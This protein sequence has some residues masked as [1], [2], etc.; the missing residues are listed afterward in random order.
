MKPKK[1]NLLLD[2]MEAGRV[3]RRQEL[4][5]F[6]KAVDRDLAA[7]VKEK[8]IE[9][10]GAGLY[11]KPMVSSFG[12]LPPEQREIVRAFLKTDDFL[13]TSLNYFNGLGVG[14]TQL[15]NEMLVYNRKRTGKFNLGG[16]VYN[17]QRPLN[18][19]RPSEINEEYLF[20]DMLNNYENLYEPPEQFKNIL[21][22]KAT[23]LK[24][25]ELLHAVN[26][27]GKVRTNKKL[28]EL[29]S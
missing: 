14:L 10:V 3:Y 25:K 12:L 23:K 28:Q 16:L 20:V 19:P 27:Y 13:L 11:Y 17:F 18:F 15:S 26:M 5:S 1:Q 24:K 6:S 22:K 7:L 29:L 8:K 9:K 4:S 21:K 2:Q